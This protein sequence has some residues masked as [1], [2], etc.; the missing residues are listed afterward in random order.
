[1]KSRLASYSLLAVLV[2]TNAGCAAPSPASL[3]R[4]STAAGDETAASKKAQPATTTPGQGNAT[5]AA[6]APQAKPGSA[7]PVG[8]D[9]AGLISNNPGGL[10]SNNAGGMPAPAASRAPTAPSGAASADSGAGIAVGEP[11]PA[12][13]PA[14]TAEALKAGAV[15]D[16]A[17]FSDYLDYLAD[18][19][20]PEANPVARP[21]KLDVAQRHVIRV[22]DADGKGVA[23]A[24]VAI[25]AGETTV[26]TVKTYADGRALFHSSAYAELAQTNAFAVSVAKGE[27]SATGTFQEDAENWEVKLATAV[28][29]P[30]AKLDMAIVID[31][32]GSMSGEIAKFQT[33]IASIASRVQ[34]LPQQPAVR[35]GLVAYKDVRE[36][37][38]SKVAAPFTTDIASFQQALNGLGAGGGGDKP[39]D[40]E[41]ALGDTMNTLAWD[42]GDTV[43]LS[44]VV[45]DAAAHTDYQ[46]NTPYT[47][48]MKRAA[49]QGIKLYPIGASSLEPE[50]EYALRQ[51]AQWT[52]GQYLFVTRGGDEA[53]GGGGTASAT[54]DKFR[55]GR[56]DDIVVDIVKAELDKL[57]Q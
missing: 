36:Q 29:T 22:V 25:K 19:A 10:I 49:E 1:M 23:N 13:P 3:G 11:N 12:Q 28:A 54:V 48:S 55:E 52:M 33:S 37:Y 45:T 44:F 21:R 41:S 27:L 9:G 42:A 50:G 8:S 30:Q 18:F 2:L 53:T 20:W 40:L 35:F 39:E 7:G 17:K 14:Q 26:A 6:S 24:T 5:G 46:Q 16:N 43:R 4:P 34:A 57:G 56:L 32:T 51:L 31:T 15:D 47:D 38:V